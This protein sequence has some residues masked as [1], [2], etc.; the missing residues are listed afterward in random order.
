MIVEFDCI[1]GEKLVNLLSFVH[2]DACLLDKLNRFV[3]VKAIEPFEQEREAGTTYG[4]TIEI[5]EWEGASGILLKV[6]TIIDKL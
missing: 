5:R 1:S 4:I 3:L 6:Y 2:S